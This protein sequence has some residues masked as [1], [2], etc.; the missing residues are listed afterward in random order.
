MLNLHPARDLVYAVVKSVPDPLHPGMTLAEPGDEIIV[1]AHDEVCPLAVLRRLPLD[2]ALAIPETSVNLLASYE[3][4]SAVPV[5]E[6]SAASRE[7]RPLK[8]L[9]RAG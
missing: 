1:R 9:G 2:L 5:S 7:A 3:P 8:L 6:Q 4:S